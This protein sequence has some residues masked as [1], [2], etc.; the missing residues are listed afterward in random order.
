MIDYER[1]RPI[2]FLDIDGVLNRIDCNG[3]TGRR[4]IEPECVWA[5]GWIIEK[6]NAAVVL[7][8]AWRYMTFDTEDHPAAVTLTGF[9]YLLKTHGL[10]VPT[11]HPIVVGTT[12]SDEMVSNRVLQIDYW[13]D[14]HKPPLYVAI[15]DMDLGN[16][17]L[18]FI[19]TNGRVGLT[20]DNAIEAARKL[21]AEI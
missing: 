4:L 1:S 3:V 15:D 12:P 10:S 8:S 19:K 18:S 2:L 16:P 9:E 11:V 17:F 7:S 21:G 14:R 13:V 6:T 5:L 20:I